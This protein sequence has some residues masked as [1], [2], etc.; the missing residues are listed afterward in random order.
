MGVTGRLPAAQL[1]GALVCAV[2]LLACRSSD[3]AGRGAGPGLQ[4]PDS[5]E[6]GDG[7]APEVEPAPSGAR[8]ASAPSPVAK[9][10]EGFSSFEPDE[11]SRVVYVSSSEGSDDFDGLSPSRP[12]KTLTKGSSLVRGGAYDFLL[13]KRG[14][15]FRDERLGCLYRTR[16]RTTGIDLSLESGHFSGIGLC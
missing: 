5:G 16:Q 4:M 12:V 6:S 8:A 9:R 2:S 3:L 11:T 1:C 10:V 13:L 14:D 15:T 7:P